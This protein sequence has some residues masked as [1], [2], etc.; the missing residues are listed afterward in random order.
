MHYALDNLGYSVGSVVAG[1]DRRRRR[2]IN[3]PAVS[4]RGYRLDLQSAQW[5]PKGDLSGAQPLHR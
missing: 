1:D 4:R 3:P 5:P 2:G